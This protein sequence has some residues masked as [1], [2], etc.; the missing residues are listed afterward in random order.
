MFQHDLHKRIKLRK[1]DDLVTDVKQSCYYNIF[2]S[3]NQHNTKRT[4]S[5]SNTTTITPATT[6]K[7]DR[8]PLPDSRNLRVPP[9]QVPI[10]GELINLTVQ[11][12]ST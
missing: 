5:L 9:L 7:H 10:I 2:P 6:P 4:A 11:A 8:P 3:Q 1:L 12:L